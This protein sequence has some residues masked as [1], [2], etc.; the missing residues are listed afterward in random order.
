M[1]KRC[2]RHGL[3]WFFLILGLL[4][5]GTA[6]SGPPVPDRTDGAVRTVA[7]GD[8]VLGYRLL[9]AG[10]PLLL[11]T[12]YGCTMERWDPAFLAALAARRQVILFDNRGMG[13]STASDRPFSLNLFA[14]DAAGL[15]AA[16]GIARA[17]VLGWSMG[18]MTALEM[19][20]S[21]PEAVGKV[22]AYGAAAEAGPVVAAIDRLTR[23][24]PAEFTDQLFPPRWGKAHPGAAAGLPQPAVAPRPE[25]VRRQREAIMAWPGFGDRLAGLDKDV[26]LVVGQDDTITAPE[27]SLKLA[28]L[29]P[30]AWLVRLRDGGHWLMYQMP[31]DLARVVVDFLEVSGRR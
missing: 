23:L 1:A 6:W 25:M 28:G 21:H 3:L 12:G 15:L 22:V 19:A 26:L 11:I 14:D 29:I 18:A 17:D 13:A 5:A 31:D 4:A 27:Q 9:G 16:L 20:R 8:V 10:E 24:T 30:G 7:V 2:L